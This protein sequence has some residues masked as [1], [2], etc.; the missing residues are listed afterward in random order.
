M[1]RERI[2]ASGEGELRRM[3]SETGGQVFKVEKNHTL[4]EIFQEIQDEMRSQ[5]ASL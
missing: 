5:Y 1:R 2:C 3:S 4:D